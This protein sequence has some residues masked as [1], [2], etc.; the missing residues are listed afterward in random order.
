L[1]RR[2]VDAPFGQTGSEISHH[3]SAFGIGHLLECARPSRSAFGWSGGVDHGPPGGGVVLDQAG[4]DEPRGGNRQLVEYPQGVLDD[5]RSPS[6]NVTQTARFGR[7]L[8]PA[9]AAATSAPPIG[10]HRRLSSLMWAA[11]G[12][13]SGTPW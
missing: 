2:E 8:A 3:S 13:A 12:S 11:N 6:S 10:T 9:S 1:I 7:T 4:A 5:A